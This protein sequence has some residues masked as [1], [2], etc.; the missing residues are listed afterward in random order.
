MMEI[1][2]WKDHCRYEH[3][4]KKAAFVVVDLC[5]KLKVLK[6]IVIRLLFE[7]S[8]FCFVFFFFNGVESHP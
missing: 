8:L 3:N 5:I 1:P 4:S 7:Y 2:Q 6:E